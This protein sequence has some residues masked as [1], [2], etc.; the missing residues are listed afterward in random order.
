M[1]WSNFGYDA[2]LRSSAHTGRTHSTRSSTRP[3]IDETCMIPIPCFRV[4]THIDS[5]STTHLS[6]FNGSAIHA[7]FHDDTRHFILGLLAFVFTGKTLVRAEQAAFRLFFLL[8]RSHG[9]GCI[10]FGLRRE[11]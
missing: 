7:M 8:G 11:E 10:P 5:I 1:Q 2:S 9:S 4:L 6:A 3:T